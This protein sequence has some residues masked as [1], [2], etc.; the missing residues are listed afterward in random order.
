MS[1]AN[2][3]T[4]PAS[5]SV[6]CIS[7]GVHS[8]RTPNP[9]STSALPHGEVNERLPC[10]A[11]RTPAPAASSAAAVEMLNVVT[12]PPPVPQVSTSVSGSRAGSCTIASRSARATP[13]RQTRMHRDERDEEREQRHALHVLIGVDAALRTVGHVHHADQLAVI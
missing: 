3:K 10:L 8:M 6:A 5:R 2:M 4:I 7:S 12:A 13:L 9:S 11:M 1:G